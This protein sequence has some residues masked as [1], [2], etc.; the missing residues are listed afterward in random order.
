[1]ATK[2]P[3]F[4]ITLDDQ[5]VPL[6]DRLLELT[7]TDK[8]GLEADQLDLTLTDHDGKLTLPRAGVMLTCAI[9]FAQ[10]SL[11]DKGSY[12][13]DEVGH[14]GTP[15]KLTI[16]ARSADFRAGLQQPKERSW[17]QTR[18]GDI[19]TTLASEHS[20]ATKI[21]DALASI[22]I[23]H[24][25]QTNES[26]ANLLTRLAKQYDAVATVKNGNL[27]LLP[28]GNG[29]SATG[30]SIAGI[31]LT[32]ADGDKH[33]YNHSD[34]QVSYTG[35]NAKWHNPATALTVEVTAGNADKPKTLRQTYPNA[36]EAQAAANAE[37]QRLQRGKHTM[38]LTLATGRPELYPQTPLTLQGWNKTI[39][40]IS[41]H[42][43]EVVHT[44][45]DSGF[46][47]KLSLEST[48]E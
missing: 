23:A 31:T 10:E 1:M 3:A 16:R 8:R 15:D 7:L 48:L 38:Q 21:D 39:D 19:V 43:V 11:H 14:A 9:G 35:V 45:N 34:R 27:M 40:A 42:L 47:S 32:R 41:W 37:W 33:S 17:H 36:A 46:V 26:D 30:R 22:A 5:A 20:L 4:A 18:V 2:T 13:V 24:I 44:I 25:D 29:K 6:A 28:I 12:T